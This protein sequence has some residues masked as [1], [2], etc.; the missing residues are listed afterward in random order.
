MTNTLIFVETD[1]KRKKVWI[2]RRKSNK[3]KSENESDMTTKFQVTPYIL[4]YEIILNN[5]LK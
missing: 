4:W 1:Y 3:K 5:V 2:E